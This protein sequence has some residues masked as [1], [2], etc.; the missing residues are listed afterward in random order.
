MY[1][2]T[3]AFKKDWQEE[4]KKTLT[5]FRSLNNKTFHVQPHPHVRSAARIA[6][7]ITDT[8][9]EMMSKTGLHID[10]Y[11]E[12][13]SDVFWNVEDLCTA[14]ES[15]SNNLIQQLSNN[16]KDA[17]L[18]EELEIYGGKQ[19]KGE[20]LQM[21][22][23]H[24]IHHRGQLTVIMRLTDVEVQGTYGPAKQEWSKYGMPVM[25]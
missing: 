10:N 13:E 2:S 23:T 4:A 7:H 9:G 22:I 14:Y 16:W 1:S 12:E 11:N 5:L 24:Q 6:W 21:L 3:E 15:Y 17:T 25:D 19:K 18:Q 20:I 8:I